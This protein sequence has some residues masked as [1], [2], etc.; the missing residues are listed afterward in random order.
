M[1]LAQRIWNWCRRFRYRCGYGVHSPSDFFLITSVVYERLPYYAYERLKKTSFSKSLPHYRE[2]VNKL[3]FRLVNFYRPG[4]LIEVG[5]GNGEAFR[6]MNQARTSMVS[7]GLKG[8][9]KEETLCRLEAELKRLEKVDFLHI[10]FTPFYKEIFEIALPYLHDES[11]V[12]VG[13]IYASAEREA[14]WKELISDERVRISF[15]LYDIGLLRFE[16][17]RFK[18]NYKVNFF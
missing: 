5:E 10:A 16:K 1:L 13:D 9:E 4:S 12:V 15:D 2:K 14:W 6:Y 7:V 11:C 18:Q 8:V 3:L 17:K